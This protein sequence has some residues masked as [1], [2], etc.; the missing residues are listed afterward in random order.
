MDHQ[1]KNLV[2]LLIEEVDENHSFIIMAHSLGGPIAISLIEQLSLLKQHKTRIAGL[3]YLEGNMDKNDAFYSSQIAKHSYQEYTKKF[4]E[5]LEH[6]QQ[7]PDEYPDG[8][9]KKAK[10]IGAFPFWATSV[11]LVSVS[12]SNQLLPRLQ[13]TLQFPV[14]F[15]FG[16]EN[17]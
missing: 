3:F 7:N 13:K 10:M 2:Q 6:I 15:V 4:E 8:Y 5:M 1:A 16:A 9:Y 12:E 11:D 14:Y 17:K